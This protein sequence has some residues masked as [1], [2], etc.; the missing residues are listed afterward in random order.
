MSIR[1]ESLQTFEQHRRTHESTADYK[2]L[3]QH[4]AEHQ[5]ETEI[6]HDVVDPPTEPCAELQFR[7][8]PRA[9][10]KISAIKTITPQTFIAV[11]IFWP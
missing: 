4:E 3:G 11:P 2:R 6:T 10:N 5:R 9:A 8:C 1:C 7:G